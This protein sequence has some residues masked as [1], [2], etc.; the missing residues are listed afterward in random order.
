MAKARKSASKGVSMGVRGRLLIAFL[1]ICMFSLI[2]AG[3]G[4]FSLSQVGGALTRITEQR[5]PQALS[6]LELSRLAER[7]VRA[8][9]ALLAVTSEDARAKVSAGIAAEARQLGPLLEQSRTNVAAEEDEA[10]REVAT[11]VD[12]L[13]KN[14]VSLDEFVKRRLFIAAERDKLVREL[15]QA[16]S[17]AVRILAPGV[18]ILDA[19][20]VEWNRSSESA[21]ESPTP[22]EAAK[23]AGSIVGLIPE[24]KGSA[25]VDSVQ[26]TLLQIASADSAENIDLLVFPLKRSLDELT[27]I[28]QGLP[29]RIK[30]R[31]VKQVGVIESLAIGEKSLAQSRKEELAVIDQAEELLAVNA[32]LSAALTDKIDQLVGGAKS[33]LVASQAQAGAVQRLNTNVLIAVVAMSF[34]SSILIVWLYVGRNLIARLTALSNSML[35]IAGGNLRAA[36]PAPGGSDEIARMAEALTVFRDNAIELEE[37]N[38]REIEAARRRLVDAIENSSEG[39]A[40]YDPDDRLVICNGKYKE[41]I[42]AGVGVSIEPG[43]TFEEI[44]RRAAESGH[45][46]N[47]RG[48]VDEWVTQRLALHRSP[49]EAR[50]Q[51]H[52]D[53]RWILISE[54]KTSDNG[55]VAVYSDITDLKQREEELAE[56]SNALEQLSNQLA[57]YLSPQIYDSIFSGRQQVRIV[58]QRKRLTVFFSDI[59]GFTETTDRLQS[60]DLTRLLNHYLTEMSQIALAHGA[61]IDKYVGDAMLIFFGDPETRGVEEDAIACVKMAIAM[62]K[63]MAELTHVWMEAGIENPLRCRIGINTGVCTV[64]NFGSETRMDYTIIG[65]AVN[66][67]SRLETACPPGEI[68]ISYE[69]HAHVKDVVFCEEHGHIEVKGFAYPIATYRVV[70]LYENLDES[71]RPIHAAL[72]H[73]QLE[74]EVKLMSE[75]ER[76]EAAAVLR[77]AVERLSEPGDKD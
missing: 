31:M 3:S 47:A 1:A 48:R 44:I 25:L 10:A 24:Q 23:L 71:S 49:S 33:E 18:R 16:N 42:H 56:K 52:D 70:D 40:F 58:S 74:A 14:L 39:F 9:P 32:K 22:E 34:L 55:T 29:E 68:L 64:G 30:G 41:L 15:V 21:T 13:N 46:V 45:I 75:E 51:E 38:L 67:A 36:L 11:L 61:T 12:N 57:K 8:A 50:M 28:A 72:P 59:T 54:R 19:Q 27:E 53:G 69:T 65:S 43:M 26:N 17:V 4:F 62:R 77:K 35:A 20:I 73:M 66:L 7:V 37:S 6:W 5:V 2:A 76:D 60:E 63:R